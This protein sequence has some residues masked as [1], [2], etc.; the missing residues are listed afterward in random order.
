MIKIL[1][2]IG[3]G[4]AGAVFGY[5]MATYLDRAISKSK[6]KQ[7]EQKAGEILDSAN[8]QAEYIKKEAALHARN[9]LLELRAEFEKETKDRR[10][11]LVSLEKRLLQKEEYLEKK[12]DIISKKEADILRRERN[13]NVSERSLSTKE[14]EY[15]KK[16]NEISIELQRISGLTTD[17]AKQLLMDSVREQAKHDIGKMLK[18][19]EDEAQQTAE[20]KA[21]EI[22]SVAIQRYSGEYAQEHTVTTVDLPNDDLKGRIIGREGRNIRAIEA[23]TG[24]DI[25]V[26]DTPQAIVISGHD[27]VKREIARLSIEKLIADGRIHPGRI[28]DIVNKTSQETEKSMKEAGERALFDLGLHGIHNELVKLIG[29]LKYRTSYAQNVYQHSMEVAFILSIMSAELGLNIKHAKRAG[30]L[31][32]IGKAVDH[33]VEGSHAVIGANLAKKY[34]EP[35]KVVEAIE[36]HHNDTPT[37]LLGI[38]LQSADALSAARPGAR[39]EMYE[40]YVKRLQDLERLST[41]FDGIDKAYAIQAG[42]EIRVIVSPDKVS[43]DEIPLLS[44]QIADRIEKEMSYPGTIKVTVLRE[45]RSSVY[46]K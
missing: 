39:R 28:E 2:A 36:Q 21:K 25:I 18:Q 37:S 11:G 35:P 46:A 45:T 10:Q 34:G 44:K 42:R 7:S 8:K 43:D 14:E 38:L 19:I 40:A 27:P 12:E 17:E 32:D 4:F 20:A 9:N 33:E 23:A 16:F 29:R 1:E 24:V 13:V 6:I 30:I 26:D 31:H 3:I 41:S 15:K 5:V 22:I